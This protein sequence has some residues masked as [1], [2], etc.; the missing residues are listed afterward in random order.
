MRKKAVGSF[1][2]IAAPC[3]DVRGQLLY[4]GACILLEA[5]PVALQDDVP[6][7]ERGSAQPP[8]G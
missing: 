7:L 1:V 8:L 6:D 3:L 2:G 4:E 5:E